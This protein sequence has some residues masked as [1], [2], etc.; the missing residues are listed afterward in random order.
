M[1]DPLQEYI[2]RTAVYVESG[3]ACVATVTRAYGE[4][5]GLWAEFRHAPGSFCC[6]MRRF[7]VIGQDPPG[8][9]KEVLTEPPFGEE[10]DVGVSAKE[11]FPDKDFWQ[12]C[13]LW[14]SG[15]RVFFQPEYIARFQNGDLTWLAEYYGDDVISDEEADDEADKDGSPR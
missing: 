15:F 10:W 6:E 3:L 14:G 9:I 11:F 2:G 13:F 8:P 12:A 7:S 5:G 4:G 1:S